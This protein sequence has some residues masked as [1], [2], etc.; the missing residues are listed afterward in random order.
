MAVL[1][2][3]PPKHNITKCQIIDRPGVCLIDGKPVFGNDW[4]LPRNQLVQAELRVGPKT[5]KPD[6]SCMYDVVPAP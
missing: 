2:F 5:I 6:V 4:G 3:E 1:P